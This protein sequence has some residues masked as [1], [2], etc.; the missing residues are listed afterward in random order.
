MDA[1]KPSALLARP[2]KQEPKV[3]YVQDPSG[4]KTG[5][6]LIKDADGKVIVQIPKADIS[7]R[8]IIDSVYKIGYLRGMSKVLTETLS[9]I[10]EAKT[11]MLHFDAELAKTID[12]GKNS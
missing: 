7:L 1:V 8:M 9:N 11:L 10:H 12:C 6:F 3:S 5:D 2:P 4:E